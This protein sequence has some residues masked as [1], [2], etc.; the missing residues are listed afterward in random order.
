MSD[1]N[2]YAVCRN[3]LSSYANDGRYV[4]GL[5]HDI[6]GDIENR[7]NLSHLLSECAKPKEDGIRLKVKDELLEIFRSL[8]REYT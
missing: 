4:G 3:L 7:Y 1:F 5:L 8:N 6:P 2:Y